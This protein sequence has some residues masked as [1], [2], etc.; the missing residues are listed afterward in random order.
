MT[1][2]ARKKVLLAKIEGTAGVDASPAAADAV[3]VE[4]PLFTPDVNLINTNEVGGSLDVSSPIVGGIRGRV[5]F[6][7]YLKGSGTAGTAPEWG[8][9]LKACGFAE[10]VTG[11]AVPAAAEALQ[12][13]TSAIAATLSTSAT[14]VAQAYLGMPVVVTST[15]TGGVNGTSF[16]SDYTTGRVATLTDTFGTSTLTTSSTFQIPVN[17]AYTPTSTDAP[18]LTIYLY[19]DGKLRKLL[20]CLG[21]F[22]FTVDA[23]GIGKFSFTFMGQYGGET[24]ASL[25]TGM[26]YQSARPPVWRGGRMLL[27]RTAAAVRQLSIDSGNTMPMPDDPNQDEGFQ[28]PLLTARNLTG[29]VDPLEVLVATNDLMA[30]FRNGTEQVIHARWGAT[31][32]NRIGITIPAGQYTAN[33]PAERDNLIARAFPFECN[34]LDSGMVITCW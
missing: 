18:S 10:T 5:T 19:E 25:P 11:T 2:R 13:G 12:S 34:G 4:N 3:L 27:N 1:A 33:N 31:A 14:N 30:A 20:G 15:A 26:A 29:S 23:G 17:V 7:V 32:G 8:K 21:N 28:V 9:L 6:D 22:T 16:I 24:D